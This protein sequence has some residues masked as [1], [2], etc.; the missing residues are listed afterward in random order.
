MRSG[1]YAP[2]VH[3]FVPASVGVE[4]SPPEF[5]CSASAEGVDFEQIIY[6]ICY[7]RIYRENHMPHMPQRYNLIH[8][9]PPILFREIFDGNNQEQG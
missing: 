2:L 5:R 7:W 6:I 1:G 4:S 9:V 3:T 8:R